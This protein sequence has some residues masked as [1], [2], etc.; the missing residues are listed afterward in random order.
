VATAVAQVEVTAVGQVV[1]TEEVVLDLVV[2][3]GTA[4][5]VETAM[6]V[7]AR[8]ETVPAKVAG[9]KSKTSININIKINTKLTRKN[10]NL[11]KNRIN[12][13]IVTGNHNKYQ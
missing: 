13:G 4:T 9:S 1:V 10:R 2:V 11:I 6:A 3:A 12:T 7:T 8:T 5:V